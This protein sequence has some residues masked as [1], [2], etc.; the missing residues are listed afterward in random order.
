MPLNTATSLI[1]TLIRGTNGIQVAAG[2]E[3][4]V[5]LIQLYDIENCPYCR[6]VREALTELDLDVLVLPC[7]KNGE[8]F[9]PELLERGGK[10]QFPY[11][12]DP[13]TG[14]EMY[15]SLDIIDYLFAT[16]GGGDLPFKWK[17]GRLQTAGS[18]LAS[19]P[20]M[21]RGM[22]ASPGAEPEQLLELYSFESSPYAR[23]VREKL[24]EMEIPYIVRNC[25]RT[26]LQEWLLPPIRNALK[27]T[28]DSAL[29][30]RRHLQHREGRVAIPYLYDPNRD[31]GLF[32][33]ADIV[34]YLDEHYR[35]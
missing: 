22:Q 23:V 7:P 29:D 20:R 33:S 24:C 32:E 12:I 5:E 10:A 15:E 19:A 17:L 18:M 25:G 27:I 34:N 8:R 4:P 21:S 14:A 1:S 31:Q 2:T 28:P 9:R 26:Q 13:N 16:Y 6:L 30:N 3:K 11:L 35:H